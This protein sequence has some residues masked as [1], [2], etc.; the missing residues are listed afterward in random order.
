MNDKFF[1]TPED[2]IMALKTRAGRAWEYLEYFLKKKGIYH[3]IVESIRNFDGAMDLFGPLVDA[4]RV[5][6][7]YAH[8]YEDC[9]SP[10]F[11]NPDTTVQICAF[12]LSTIQMCSEILSPMLAKKNFVVDK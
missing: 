8:V 11:F 9:P 7:T 12:I 5:A 2:V 1:H 6:L 4:V 10:H 3:I